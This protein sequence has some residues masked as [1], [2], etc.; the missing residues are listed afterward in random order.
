LKPE[1]WGEP[2]IQDKYQEK[3]NLW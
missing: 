3:G 2:V 1:W